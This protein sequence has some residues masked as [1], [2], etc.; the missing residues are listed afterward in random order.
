MIRCGHLNDILG[1]V[2]S[3]TFLAHHLTYIMHS[4]NNIM[5]MVAFFELSY[6]ACI[7]SLACKAYY[8]ET[9]W[10]PMCDKSE[11]DS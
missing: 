2:L 5:L 6:I 3:S 11:V 9:M 1:G 10:P 4:W 7:Y 8:K